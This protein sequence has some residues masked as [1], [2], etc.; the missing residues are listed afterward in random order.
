[1]NNT[2]GGTACV[3]ASSLATW[4]HTYL[5]NT[6]PDPEGWSHAR[7]K[8]NVFNGASEGEGQRGGS[9]GL[10]RCVA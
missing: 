8:I 1:M 7:K 3:R 6:S 4:H 10:V 5:L 2:T 9:R